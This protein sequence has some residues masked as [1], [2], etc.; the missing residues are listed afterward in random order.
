MVDDVG[1]M[2]KLLPIRQVPKLTAT[3]VDPFAAFEA[4]NS[5]MPIRSYYSEIPSSCLN[6]CTV[7]RG[8]VESVPSRHLCVLTQELISVGYN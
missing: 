4:R 7:S 2:R 5:I 3:S 8:G 6:P 1:A